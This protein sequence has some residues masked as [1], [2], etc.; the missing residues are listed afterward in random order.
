MAWLTDTERKQQNKRL[1]RERLAAAR[2]KGRHTV[3]Q[4]AALKIEFGF[5]CVRCLVQSHP[6]GDFLVKDHIEPIYQGGSDGIDNLQPLCPPCNA[7]KG[8]EDFNWKEYRRQHGM[9]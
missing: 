5:R 8:P 1:R 9:D 4:W 7:S 6:E 2:A 3:E